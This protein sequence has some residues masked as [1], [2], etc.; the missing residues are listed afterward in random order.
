MRIYS[1]EATHAGGCNFCFRYS[2]DTHR[3]P[4]R[5]VIILEGDSIQIRLCNDCLLELKIRLRE[6]DAT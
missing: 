5:K 1:D 3:Y 2:I 4:Y 6:Y